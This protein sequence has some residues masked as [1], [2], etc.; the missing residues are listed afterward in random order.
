MDR[1]NL[2]S[3]VYALVLL[4]AVFIVWKYRE[5]NKLSEVYFSG[6]T[7][8]TIIYNIKYLDKDNRNFQKAVDSLL[9]D[10]NQALSTYIP[11]SE[12]SVFNRDHEV[13]FELPYFP[14]VLAASAEVYE[15]SGGAFDPTVGQLVDAWGFGTEDA[16]DPDSAQVDSLLEYVGFDKI[17]FDA[18]KVS[19]KV[20]GLRLN[21]SAVAKGQAI[22]VVGDYLASQGVANYM[23]EIGGE[24]RALGKN[25]EGELWTIG[26]EIPDERQI[27]GL[28]DAVKLE[29]QGMATSGN[30]RIFRVLPDG[31]K[32]AHT[33]DPK[34]GFPKMHTLLSA[35]V[36]APNCMYA[37]AYATACMAMGLEAARDMILADDSLEAYFIYADEQGDI[38]TYIS[39]GMTNKVAS[40]TEGE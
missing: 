10:F 20:E 8:G 27:G 33:I 13:A 40:L 1:R 9:V 34:T 6:T 16:I 12:I 35:T 22:D 4:V 28:F 17:S 25:Q 3:R 24:V 5:A 14:E 29:N 23:V 21:F 11:D 39:P 38:K 7:M 31:R 36:F 32:V 30:Y 15:K 18:R 37:D 26:I 2:R 19:K